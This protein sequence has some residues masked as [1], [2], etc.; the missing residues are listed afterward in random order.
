MAH[1]LTPKQKAFCEH[2]AACGN[3]TDAAKLA[4]YSSPNKQGSQQFQKPHVKA[5]Y[6]SLMSEIKN[7]RIA[8]AIERQEFLTQ[9]MRGEIGDGD[10]DNAAK[11]TDRIK[12]CIELAKLQGDYIERSQVETSGETKIIITHE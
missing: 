6:D 9:M 5:Y 4:D 1:S 12:A 8:D 10:G 7:E 11:N 2:Y 3:L